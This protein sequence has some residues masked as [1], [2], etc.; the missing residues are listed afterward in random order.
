MCQQVI[1][2]SDFEQ[3]STPLDILFLHSADLVT[4]V[5]G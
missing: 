3:V 5:L 2:V 1:H 4:L